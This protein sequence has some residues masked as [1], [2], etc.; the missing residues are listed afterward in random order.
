MSGHLVLTFTP[1]ANDRL[2][3]WTTQG[4]PHIQSYTYA[5]KVVF[6]ARWS[7]YQGGKSGASHSTDRNP[8]HTWMYVLL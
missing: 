2:F 6:I 8:V 1:Y 4:W 3:M 5:A 7:L